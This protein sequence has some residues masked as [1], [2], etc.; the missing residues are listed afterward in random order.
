M[1]SQMNISHEQ[2]RR[3]V[4]SGVITEE[5]AAQ[6]LEHLTSYEYLDV[7][8]PISCYI[9]T[10]GGCVASALLMYDSIKSCSCPIVTIGTGRVMSAGILL[11]AAG[12][13]GMRFVT[14]NT[15][16]LMHQ[17]SSGMFGP[18]SDMEASLAETKELQNIFYGL[19]SK[20]T[21]VPT[22][23]IMKD[24]GTTDLYMSAEQ[25]VKYGIADKIV[26]SRKQV[27]K[28]VVKKPVTKKQ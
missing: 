20:E 21:G 10:P 1:I 12:Q 15:R 5:C 25:A 9:S 22:K 3:I 27:K 19:L 17:I 16:L 24:I 4:I 7:N 6:F 2:I 18:I 26:P 28:V 11:L 8:K 13:R 14:E 23:T